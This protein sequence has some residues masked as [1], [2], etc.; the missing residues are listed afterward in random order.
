VSFEGSKS[1]GSPVV[2][3]RI[4]HANTPAM[5]ECFLVGEI[6]LDPSQPESNQIKFT[7]DPAELRVAHHFKVTAFNAMG[8]SPHSEV[9]D[10]AIIGN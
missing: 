5:K 4:Y 1:S 7:Y 10:K 6:K 3:Y 8:E 2:G 9:S